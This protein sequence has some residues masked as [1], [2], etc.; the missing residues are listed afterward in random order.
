MDQIL[1]EI[2][3]ALARKGLSDA[4][5]S[6]L[7]VGHPSLIKNFRMERKGEKRYNLSS[8]AKL[9]DVLDL[10]LYFGPKRPR[11]ALNGFAEA[12][13]SRIEPAIDGSG[14]A[15]R[16]GFLPIP[17][18]LE[19]PNNRGVAPIALARSWLA[20]HGL[21]PEHLS[22]ITQPNGNMEP[23]ISFGEMMLVDAGHELN[24]EPTLSAF[25]LDGEVGVGWA[26][27]PNQ[28]SVV[29]F[30]ENKYTVPVVIPKKRGARYRHLGR[31]AARVDTLPKPWLAADE[32]L[33]ILERAAQLIDAG[34]KP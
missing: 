26:V 30:Y 20:D 7:A 14:E 10:E 29:I 9:A 15:L 1:E 4:A 23:S 21:D 24:P 28:E 8:L 33:A 13:V 18:S 25:V 17:Y 11:E 31:I 6:R 5:A 32:K 12:A 3:K 34:S 2:D 16:Q 27:G 19:D 22:F